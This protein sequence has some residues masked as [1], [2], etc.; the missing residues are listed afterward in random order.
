[1]ATPRRGG[2]R[3]AFLSM[4]RARGCWG[5][6]EGSLGRRSHSFESTPDRDGSGWSKPLTDRKVGVRRIPGWLLVPVFVL[7]WC[8]S[9]AAAAVP[10]PSA[11]LASDR[12]AA[13]SGPSCTFN[14]SILPVVTGLAPGKTVN[15]SCS[16]LAPLHPYLLVEAS[17]L[18][19]IDP[20]AAA[21]FSGGVSLGTLLSGLEALP[22]VN[23]G[24]LSF[25]WSDLFGRLSTTWTVPSTQAVDP[26]ASCPPSLPEFNSGLIGCVLAM[27]DLTALKPVTAGS[28]VLNFSGYPLLPPNPT[29]SLSSTRAAP[30][31]TVSVSDVPGAGTYWWIATVTALGSLLTGGAVPPVKVT[32][33]VGS[34]AAPSH[35][36]VTPASYNGTT[37]TPPKLSGSFVV[38]FGVTGVKTVTVTATGTLL[39]LSLPISAEATLKVH[40]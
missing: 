27:I 17:P 31:A 35:V 32:V 21:L 25:P 22:E 1:M 2:F 34:V 28:P 15:I 14:G 24:S 39:V 38:P 9:V 29:L 37:L 26:N 8:P 6:L 13:A 20:K 33:K 7:I 12:I 19:G 10:A 30:G 18:V 5:H 3:V 16:G 40:R 11:A 23:P 36:V 4:A